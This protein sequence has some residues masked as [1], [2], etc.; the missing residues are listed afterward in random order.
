MGWVY[1]QLL[2]AD[3][4]GCR[5]NSDVWDRMAKSPP[6]YGILNQDGSDWHFLWKLTEDGVD[7]A[8]IYEL[9]LETQL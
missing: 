4:S 2:K 1:C 3:E 6:L 7:V 8:V 5:G 9:G